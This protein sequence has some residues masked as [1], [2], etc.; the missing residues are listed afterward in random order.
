MG[1]SQSLHPTYVNIYNKL[2]LI[3]APQTR[4]QMIETCL[5]GPEYVSAAKLAGVYGQLLAYV[6]HVRNGLQPPVLPG[7]PSRQGVAYRNGLPQQIMQPP[8]ITSHHDSL[9]SQYNPYTP[10]AGQ[11]ITSYEE[12]QVPAWQ[13]IME[14]PQKKALSYFESC[15]QVL[16]IRE[17]ETL[18]EDRLKRAY[19]K[20]AARVHPDKGGSEHEFE[21]VTR[22]YAYISEIMKRMQGRQATTGAIAAP[23]AVAKERK[24]DMKDIWSDDMKP[25]TIDPKNMNMT[26]FNQ[27]FEQARIP[28]P[29]DDGYGDWLKDSASGDLAA[30]GPKFSGQFNREVFNKTFEQ[31]A[32][33]HQQQQ[34]IAVVHPRDMAL[35]LSAGMGVELGRDRPTEYTAAPNEKTQFTD[36]R[37]AYTTRSTFSGEVANVR[38][39][40]R[41]LKRYQADRESAPPPLSQEEAAQIAAAEARWQQQ[42]QVRL[43]RAAEEQAVAN[44]QFER[45]KRLMIVNGSRVD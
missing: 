17:D 12:K 28:D 30:S 37:A 26:V 44:Q 13:Q 27:L 34:Q 25:V 14:A 8:Q 39:E 35:T 23:N 11:Q 24:K 19:K 42:E 21:A 1:N 43:R 22:A 33:A 40:G 16:G 15:L 36:L 32:V 18:T 4:V 2:I 45:M 38:T 7:E 41:D 31:H 20:T 6:S 10:G 3:Q 29:D 9:R 5:S